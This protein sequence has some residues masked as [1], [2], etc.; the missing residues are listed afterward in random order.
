[1]KMELEMDMDSYDDED[2]G[3]WLLI[4]LC[5]PWRSNRKMEIKMNKSCLADDD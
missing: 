4:I 3:N 5:E 2:I 1:M